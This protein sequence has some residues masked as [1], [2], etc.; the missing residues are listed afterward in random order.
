MVTCAFRF[1]RLKPKK[2]VLQRLKKTASDSSRLKQSSAG[3]ELGFVI[4]NNEIIRRIVLSR[5]SGILSN[6]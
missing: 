3:Q 1:V 6:R 2:L 4:K 5:I